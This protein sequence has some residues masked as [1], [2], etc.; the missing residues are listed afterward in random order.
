MIR[1]AI[2]FF[3]VALIAAMFGF[4]GLAHL[5]AGIGKSIL[6]VFALLFVIGIAMMMMVGNSLFGAR[7]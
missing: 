4:G 3:V 1:A 2:F 6:G 5:S 7:T